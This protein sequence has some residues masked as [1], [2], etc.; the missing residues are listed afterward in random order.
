MAYDIERILVG[1][2]DAAVGTRLSAAAAMEQAVREACEVGVLAGGEAEV[3]DRAP[4]VAIVLSRLVECLGDPHKGVQVHSANALEL[5]SAHS[6]LVMPALREALVGEDQWR[7]W[8]AAI[9]VA[10]MGQWF[11]ELGPALRGAMGATDRDVRWAAAGYSLALGRNHS[12][13]VAMVAATL[14][15]PSPLARKMAAYCLGGMGAYAPGVEHALVARLSDPERDV[16]RAVLLAIDKLPTVSAA[17]RPQ[18]GALR[19]DPDGFVRRTAG[20]VAAKLGA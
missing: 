8:G 9:V 12:E 4:F 10:R 11:P 19:G 13:A 2:Q 18:V 6:P 5:L 15:A 7:A 20:A 17:V 16:R 3:Q 1:L 14:D